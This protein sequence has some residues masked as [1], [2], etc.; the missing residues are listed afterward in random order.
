MQ[1]V[2]PVL[3][4][5]LFSRGVDPTFGR[6]LPRILRDH[7]LVDVIADA[8]FPLAVPAVAALEQVNTAQTRDGLLSRGITAAEIDRFLRLLGAGRL[9]LAT[10]PL[11]SATGRRPP[12]DAG[13]PRSAS[14]P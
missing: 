5:L 12:G 2:T 10:A 14:T 1:F 9:D 11:I 4:A 7:G 13:Q 6:R 3:K 8:Y